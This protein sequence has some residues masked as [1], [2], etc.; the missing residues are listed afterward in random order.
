MKFDYTKQVERSLANKSLR[1][2][3][4]DDGNLGRNGGSFTYNIINNN[5]IITFSLPST[6]IES[7]G[8]K[9]RARSNAD[10]G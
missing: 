7:V 3:E 6:K 2:D 5:A 1:V 9:S 4:V 8:P 10:D